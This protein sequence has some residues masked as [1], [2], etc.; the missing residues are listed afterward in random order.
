MSYQN[1]KRKYTEV[2]RQMQDYYKT[3]Q[4]FRKRLD[5]IIE[6]IYEELIKNIKDYEIF[7]LY[8][9]ICEVESTKKTDINNE[10]ITQ[11]IKNYINSITNK[12]NSNK[13]YSKHKLYKLRAQKINK[14]KII[15]HKKH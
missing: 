5:K 2:T 9:I 3:P 12:S 14:Y 8:N 4:E 10:E 1:Y 7:K 15:D 13:S 6:N 11:I